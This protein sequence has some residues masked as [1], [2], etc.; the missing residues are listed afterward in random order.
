MYGGRGDD[1]LHSANGIA[2]IT[3]GAGADVF[4]LYRSSDTVTITDFVSGEDRIKFDYDAKISAS[5]L[6]IEAD[7]DDILITR[8]TAEQ[9]R[10]L[11][12]SPRRCHAGHF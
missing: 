2:T 1:V 6:R 11:G 12:F 5:D 9:I 10:L 3:G 4:K 8:P 7:G